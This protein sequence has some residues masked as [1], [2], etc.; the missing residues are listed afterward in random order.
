MVVPRE[1]FESMRSGLAVLPTPLA[2][3]PLRDAAS[4]VLGVPNVVNVA[5]C[6]KYQSI[7]KASQRASQP[8]AC[9]LNVHLP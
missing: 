6:K 3:A 5:A 1:T 2:G 8:L 9:L 4:V 7:L